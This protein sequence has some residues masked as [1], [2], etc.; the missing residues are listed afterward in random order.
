MFISGCFSYL[1]Y[2]ATI[3]LLLNSTYYES[4]CVIFSTYVPS[5]YFLLIRILSQN[6]ELFSLTLQ[7]QKGEREKIKW[8][9]SDTTRKG[10]RDKF[11]TRK[12]PR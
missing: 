9:S 4:F 8:R 5:V 2:L 6:N 7:V 10:G 1:S 11:A 12:V 3:S